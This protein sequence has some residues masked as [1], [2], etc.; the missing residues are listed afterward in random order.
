MESTLKY[1]EKLMKKVPL[2][3]KFENDTART[4][5][6]LSTKLSTYGKFTNLSHVNINTITSQPRDSRVK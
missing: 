3:T 5:N 6:K 1:F 4:G 2:L